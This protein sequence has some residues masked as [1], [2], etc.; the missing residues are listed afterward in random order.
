MTLAKRRQAVLEGFAAMFGDAGAA[1]GRVHRARLD[2]GAL[3]RRRA[4]PRSTPPTA[5]SAA[6]APPIRRPFGRVHWAGTE[7]ST[8]WSGYMDG[9]VRSGERAALEVAGAAAVRHRAAVRPVA[10]LALVA[11]LLAWSPLG[12]ATAP[13]AGPRRPTP[14]HTTRVFSRVPSPGH[15]AYVHVSRNGRVYAG[16]YESGDA[17]ALPRPRVA[18]P[19]ARCC[20]R[21]PCPARCSTAPGRPGR[22]R[23]PRRQA[24]AARD[25]DPLAC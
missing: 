10:A 15:P 17:P 16:T 12:T 13:A 8:Y 25:L 24:G 2:Q 21:G 18:P 9:A 5:R 20:G 6:T 22:Q 23:D 19:T 4:P 7:T 14:S 1:P 11:A 3:D